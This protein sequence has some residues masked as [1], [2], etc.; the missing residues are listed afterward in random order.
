ML[1]FTVRYSTKKILSSDETNLQDSWTIVEA[2]NFGEA[3]KQVNE[4]Y[5]KV[6]KMTL[7]DVSEEGV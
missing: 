7:I 4:S 5:G 1:K 2:E 6:Y 3:A